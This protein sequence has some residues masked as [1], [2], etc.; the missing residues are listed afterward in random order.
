[1]TNINQELT[2][3]DELIGTEYIHM[4]NRISK[5]EDLGK[6][7]K[8]GQFKNLFD[9]VGIMN[10]SDPYQ[11][12]LKDSEKIFFQRYKENNNLEDLYSILIS[13]ILQR[14]ISQAEDTVNLIL[15]SDYKNGNT[16]LTKAII[17]LYSFDKG[18]ARISLENAKKNSKSDQS[19]DILKTIDG[20]TLLLEMKF[21]NA[22]KS[23]T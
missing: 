20:L 16:Y 19:K 4:T 23:L 9:L 6:F 3:K 2:I 18:N 15:K 17:N 7:L 1:M 13:Q 14:K 22:F 10:Q 5:V 8:E 11:I 12:Y 21:I